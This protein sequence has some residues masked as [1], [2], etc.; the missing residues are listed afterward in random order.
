[1]KKKFRHILLNGISRTIRGSRNSKRK[2]EMKS[3]STSLQLRETGGGRLLLVRISG[4][5]HRSDYEIFVPMVE[6]MIEEHGKVR[7][8]VEL[9]DFEGW[10]AGA[11]W[12]D[13]KFDLR[14][15]SDFERLA[16]VG[17]QKWEKGM[18]VFCKP[19]TK[20]EVQFFPVEKREE[21]LAWASEGLPK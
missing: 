5:L 9:V 4:K 12:E 1:M 20:A 16:L 11:L 21:A 6:N 18:A 14:H 19:F 10:S 8:L 17:D 2:N 15:F 13:V 7:L 3:E